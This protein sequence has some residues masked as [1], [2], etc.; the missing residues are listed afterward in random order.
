VVAGSPA[1]LHLDRRDVAAAFV[2]TP[3]GDDFPAAVDQKRGTITVTATE[4]PGNYVVRAGGEAGGIAKGF[5]VNLPASATDFARLDAEPLAAVLGAGHRLA[6]TEADLV[7]DVN[8]ER[9]G[10]ELFG[11]L[12]LLAAAVMAADWIVAN[13]FYAP[14]EGAGEP[15]RPA[16]EFAEAATAGP[17][18]TRE[19]PPAPPPIPPS[20]AGPPPVPPPVPP[21]GVPA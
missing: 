12:V 17:P 9:V 7:R 5:S 11:W 2:R 13:R 4:V 19:P 18:P 1:V 3:A 20:A 8:L 15:S 14:R 16:E 6:R 10:T 21:P